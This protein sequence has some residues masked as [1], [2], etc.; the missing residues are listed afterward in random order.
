ML[1]IKLI[2]HQIYQE[3]WGNYLE[4]SSSALCK[5]TNQHHDVSQLRN[6]ASD[7]PDCLCDKFLLTGFCKSDILS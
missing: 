1:L 2:Y 5:K 6:K 3:N 7:L 4:S